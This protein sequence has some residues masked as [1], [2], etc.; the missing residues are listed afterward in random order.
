MTTPDNNV[1][2]TA[3]AV[4]EGAETPFRRFI[5]D[6][7]ESRVALFGVAIFLGIVFIAIFA[8]QISPQDPYDLAQLDIMDGRLEPGAENADALVPTAGYL[9]GFLANLAICT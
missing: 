9:A 8:P 5:S 3:D 6:F 1:V 7:C 4:S 2:E